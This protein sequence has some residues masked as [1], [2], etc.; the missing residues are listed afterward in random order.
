MRYLVVFLSL[1]GCNTPTYLNQ[2]RPLETT[3]DPMGQGYVD[4]TDLYTLPVRRPTQDERKLI[5]DEQRK[6][7][8]MMPVPW[9]GTRDFALQIEYSVKNLD[10]HT[11]TAYFSANGGNEFGDYNPKLY[12]NMAA[13]A[14][15]QTPPP[16]LL[17]GSPMVLT[18]GQT[19]EG[20]FREDQIAEESL[21]LEA[22]TRYPS[23]GD[24]M[25]TPF[26]VILHDS[27]ASR[28]GLESVPKND[29]TPLWVRYQFILSADGHVV[30]D[31]NVRVRELGVPDDK[32]ASPTARGLYVST[33][34]M[35]TPPANPQPMMMPSPSPSPGP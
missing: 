29:V 14:E 6:L 8:L 26:M 30:C 22:I 5:G 3:A 4:D 27:T 15:D 32:L 23:N 2:H 11:V 1:S 19:F 21:D 18:K 13:N 10:D 7:G 34:A 17:G 28:V 25:G 16:P 12:I 33:A 35:V 9:V 20:V 24:V 31:Y